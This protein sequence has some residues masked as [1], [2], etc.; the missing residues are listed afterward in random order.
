[1]KN[2]GDPNLNNVHSKIN[3]GNKKRNKSYEDILEKEKDFF[4]REKQILKE[5]TNKKKKKN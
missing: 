3:T 2:T 4:G 1:M 5:Q